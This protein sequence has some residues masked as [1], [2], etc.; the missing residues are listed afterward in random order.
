MRL[1]D[2]DEL[3]KKFKSAHIGDV[4]R[5]IFNS[6]DLGYI[7]QVIDNAETVE[8]DE[9]VIQEVLN[10]K[11]MTAVPNEYLIALRD[12]RPQGEWIT[13]EGYDGDEYYECSV[14]K[15]AFV[16]MAG[17]PKENNYNYCPNCGADMRGGAE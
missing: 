2:A 4:P 9:S 5:C 14:C 3:K 17:T 6:R 7:N 16:L 12:T 1:I 10:K 11:C 13:Q 8:L 15:D